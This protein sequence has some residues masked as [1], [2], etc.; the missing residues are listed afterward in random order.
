MQKAIAAEL[1]SCLKIGADRISS[2]T[3]GPATTKEEDLK[4]DAEVITAEG[5][6][7]PDE[8]K[9]T[10]EIKP[11]TGLNTTQVIDKIRN[12]AANPT[13]A[14]STAK[15]LGALIKASGLT[16]ETLLPKT[17]C[18]AAYK[19]WNY[20]DLPD[21]AGPVEWKKTYPKCGL[22]NV[23]SPIR[24]PI[25]TPK[26]AET[27]FRRLDFD[28]K[29]DKMNLI[30]DGRTLMYMASPGSAMRV[31]GQPES[32]SQLQY[33][34]F[35]SPSEHVFTD[36]N[37]VDIRYAA[38]LQLHHRNKKT[39]RL[40]VVAVLLKV[41][42]PSPFLE[43]LFAKIPDRCESAKLT[44][45]LKWEDVLPFSR[46][47]Y[48][49]YGTLTTPPCTDSVTWYVLREQGTISLEQLEKIRKKLK[50]DIAK[51][52]KEVKSVGT[53]LGQHA[54]PLINKD[55]FPTY[56]FSQKLMG[57]ARPL[58]PLGTRKL[59]STPAKM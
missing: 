23:Q 8:T 31:S 4:E 40:V 58:Q 17:A 13:S 26:T 44:D 6:E 25:A 5:E 54:M 48:M 32:E 1:E 49:Y 43:K 42:A 20:K 29:P 28:Y 11:G 19:K 50:L 15:T 22:P 27:V 45:A 47:Y 38:E 46:T 37:G 10:V 52:P 16:V 7:G 56:E 35:H 57:D 55:K 2:V 41:N 51:A 34:S 12:D 24:L 3:V 39:G 53:A 33:V 18:D 59:W 36:A 14:L 30:N 9:V 21:K